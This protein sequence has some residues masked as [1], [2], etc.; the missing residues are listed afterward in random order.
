MREGWGKLHNEEHHNLHTSENITT[1]KKSREMIWTGYLA[2][3]EKKKNYYNALMRKPEEMR[4]QGRYR[5]KWRI[6]LKW[7]LEKYDGVLWSELTWLRMGPVEGFCEHCN[8][9]LG[10]VKC[11]ILDCLNDCWLLKKD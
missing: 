9:H 3:K 5:H 2:R 10:F 1:I 4:P 7:L 6:L 8:E 11:E